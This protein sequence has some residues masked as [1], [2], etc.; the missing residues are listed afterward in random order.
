MTRAL[1]I[2]SLLLLLGAGFAFTAG[3][4]ALGERQDLTALYWLA[5]GALTLRSAVDLLRPRGGA[6]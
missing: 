1:D 3:V 2:A 4:V 5:V 6:R